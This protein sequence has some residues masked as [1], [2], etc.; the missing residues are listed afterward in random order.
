[1]TIS[2][3]EIMN[4]TDYETFNRL[5][6]NKLDDSFD[7]VEDVDFLHDENSD[8]KGHVYITYY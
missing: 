7:G 8:S 3:E 4:V 1:M 5:M 6:K 2:I